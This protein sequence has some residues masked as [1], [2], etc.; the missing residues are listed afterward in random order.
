MKNKTGRVRGINKFL[1]NFS[2]FI[3]IFLTSFSKNEVT[4]IEALP[5]REKANLDIEV[6]KIKT[7]KITGVIYENENKIIFDFKDLKKAAEKKRIV[8]DSNNYEI[9]ILEN[10]DNAATYMKKNEK[11]KMNR[12]FEQGVKLRNGEKIK[13]KNISYSLIEQ[14][15]EKVLEV[16]YDLKPETFYLGV[17]NNKNGMVEKI[18]RAEFTQ[19]K[20]AVHSNIGSITDFTYNISNNGNIIID[21]NWSGDYT[22]APITIRF[23]QKTNSESQLFPVITLGDESIWKKENHNGGLPVESSREGIE[24]EFNNTAI[25]GKMKPQLRY[26]T[27]NPS[28]NIGQNRKIYY[29]NILGDSTNKIAIGAYETNKN[30][31]IEVELNIKIDASTIEE[32][33]SY[34]SNVPGTN[35]LVE[36]PYKSLGISNQISL[37]IGNSSGNGYYNIPGE[38]LTNNRITLSYPKIYIRKEPDKYNNYFGYNIKGLK[39][40]II[41]ENEIDNFSEN[42]YI[43]S[44]GRVSVEKKATEVGTD[45]APAIGLGTQSD[46]QYYNEWINN[47]NNTIVNANF[48]EVPNISIN[49]GEKKSIYPYL[50][51]ISNS[52]F[53]FQKK[54][55]RDIGIDKE[56]RSVTLATYEK[57]ATKAIID[58]EIKIALPNET[59]K[60]IQKYA[61][62]KNEDIVEIPYS[63]NYKISLIPSS[64]NNGNTHIY[65]P[66]TSLGEVREILYPKIKFKK[67][68]ENQN[69]TGNFEYDYKL[70]NL[71][72]GEKDLIDNGDLDKVSGFIDFKQK[73]MSSNDKQIP[74]IALGTKTNAPN[75]Y[76]F[77]Q[78]TTSV[79]RNSY[80]AHYGNNTLKTYPYLKDLKGG[81]IEG[82]STIQGGVQNSSENSNLGIWVYSNNSREE[83]FAKLAIKI[84]NEDKTKF[85]FHVREVKAMDVSLQ[86]EEKI[87]FVQGSYSDNKYKFPLDLDST[88]IVEVFYPHLVIKKDLIINENIE[89]EFK[90]SY[91]ERTRVDFDI[92]GN[93]NNQSVEVN[94]NFGQFM[95]GLELNDGTLEIT[96][97]SNNNLISMVMNPSGDTNATIQKPNLN[98]NI[99]YNKNGL[100]SLY[101]NEWTGNSHT[102]KIIHKEKSGLIRRQYTVKLKTPGPTFEV[103]SAQNLDFG[104]VLKGDNSK[105]A[106]S[107]IVIKNLSSS[108]LTLK[109]HADKVELINGNSKITASDFLISEETKDGNTEN[110]YF[111]LNGKLTNTSTATIEGEHIGYIH[112]NVNLN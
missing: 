26:K 48:D 81:V 45:L 72:I 36:I 10:L 33:K 101:L 22:S 95:N 34:V 62:T 15:R 61:Y 11:F 43:I 40:H 41:D 93:P 28:G 30:E 3:C 84:K 38:N 103:I 27:S 100:V 7:E 77:N 13:L 52:G 5:Q 85:L 69:S 88:R 107:K 112:L 51:R 78:N 23:E 66:N 97:E 65:I 91:T 73:S 17:L 104:T 18:Y 57:K 68:S 83:V 21:S 47:N 64:A 25:V 60:S 76:L 29:H 12:V 42:F 46:W 90:N 110:S 75:G 20:T 99:N 82:N 50:K 80:I 32:I 67:K 49:I 86:T 79:N 89:I 87:G 4:T 111:I 56:N 58:T 19:E 16:S 24:V 102:L 2:F 71:E 39:D 106:A 70:N 1:I 31:F 96:D 8:T 6:L 55:K 94:L 37:I 109:T 63:N 54:L 92:A 105:T 9:F 44:L 98:M 74:M 14:N 53:L 108:P 35:G 59:L